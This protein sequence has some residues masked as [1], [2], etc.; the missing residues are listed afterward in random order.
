MLGGLHRRFP[1]GLDVVHAV[2]GEKCETGL[3]CRSEPF[4]EATVEKKVDGGVERDQ[5]VGEV[6]VDEHFRRTREFVKEGLHC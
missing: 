2:L 4:R 3:E 1:I 5:T 6:I